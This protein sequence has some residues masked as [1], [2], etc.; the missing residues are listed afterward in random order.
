MRQHLPHRRV[1]DK[2]ERRRET[3][4]RMIAGADGCK[5]G[6]VVALAPLSDMSRPQVQVVARLAD[7]FERH[8]DLLLAVDMPIG[9]PDRIEGPGRAPE[10][11]VRPLLGARQ[12]SV[13]SIPARA[14]IYAP[15]YAQ[16]CA[17]AAANSNPPRK[18]SKQGFFLFPKVREIDEW[19]RTQP[20]LGKRVF[21]SH[22]EVIFRAL[23]GGPLDQPKKVKGRIWTDGIEL[24]QR[25]LGAAG[26]APDTLA[27]R[28]PKG[29]GADDYLDALACLVTARAIALGEAESFPS[30]PERDAHGLPIAI[31]APRPHKRAEP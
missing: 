21:E 9:L 14:A 16:A 23:N 15:D 25:L 8:P 22:P 20:E 26:I 12:S 10:Q 27:A 28:A 29:A 6:W 30:P 18:V 7:L 31:W 3:R 1:I 5:A 17:L 11:L 2:C 19:L 24:R 4:M 13:F